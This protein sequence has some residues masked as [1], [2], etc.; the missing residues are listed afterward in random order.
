MSMDIY[1][2]GLSAPEDMVHQELDD[3]GF[4]YGQ[5]DF[6]AIAQPMP[7]RPVAQGTGV[8]A[9]RV[10]GRGFGEQFA[11]GLSGCLG[12]LRGQLQ[13]LGS[14]CESWN[15]LFLFHNPASEI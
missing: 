14:R 12:Q 13:R 10:D 5:G 15:R 4:A 8:T 7:T 11:Y 3:D 9:R 1:Q 6:D 2:P